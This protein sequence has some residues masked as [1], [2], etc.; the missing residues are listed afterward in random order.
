ME[1]IKIRSV[2]LLMMGVTLT[3][4]AQKSSNTFSGLAEE[5]THA[6][7]RVTHSVSGTVSDENGEPIIGA[8]IHARKSGEVCVT[9]ANGKFS[10]RVSDSDVLS[11]SYVGFQTKEVV[12]KDQKEVKVVL[13]EDAAL[14]DEFVVIGYGEVKKKDLT[15]SVANVEGDVISRMQSTSLGQSLQGLMAGVDVTRS[16]STPNANASIKVR[17]IT[18]I[19][20]SSPLIVV[21]GV[22]VLS[23]EDVDGDM[24]E[25]VTVLKDAASASIYGSRAAAGVIL[26][27]TK[28]AQ[29]GQL[30]ISYNGT[31]GITKRTSMPGSVTTKRY[32]EM[33]NE[34][35]WNDGGNQEGQE[36]PIY[37]KEY[38]DNYM[39]N[40]AKDPDQYPLTDWR[41]LMLKKTATRQKHR[42]SMTYGNDVIKT[43][44]MVSYEKANALYK[45]YDYERF[46]GRVNSDIKFNKYISASLDLN[47]IRE[48]EDA[49][50]VNPLY[51]ALVNGPTVAALW[52]DGRIGEAHNGSNT[53]ARLEYGGTDSYWLNRFY[54]KLSI[55]LT[56]FR[57]FSITGV[58]NPSIST[59]S[60][61]TFI[62]Q[63]PY[64]SAEDPLQLMG[65]IDGHMTSS[66]TE[67]RNEQKSLTKQLLLNYQTQFQGKHNLALMAGYEDYYYK[68]ENLSVSGDRF[69]LS[70]FPY[71]DRAP[72]DYLSSS[73]NATENAYQSYFGRVTYDYKNRYLLQGNIRCDGSSR[74]HKDHRWGTFPSVSAGWV[75]T[76]EP[77][78]KKMGLNKLDFLKL[79]A[80]YGTLGNER[81]GN[82]PYQSIMNLHTVIM[83]QN[84]DIVTAT[85]AAQEVYNIRDISWETTTSWNIGVDMT[86]LDGRLY[87][88]GDVYRKNTKDMLLSLEIPSF[89]G[90]SR[91]SQN[92]GDMHT[93]GWEIQATWRDKI[94]DVR[95][96]VGFHISD[97]RSIMGNLSGLVMDSDKIICEGSEYNEWYGYVSDGLFQSDEDIKNSA[98][99]FENVRP[100]D[101]KYKDISGPEGVPDGKISA[102]YDRVTLG[103]SLPRF[104]Y[105]GNIGLDWKGIDFSLS[106]QGVGKQKCRM[107][108]KMV[109][110]TTA[111][112]T[113]PELIEGK[114]W[115]EYNTAEE[116]LN[117]R[118]PRLSQVGFKSNNYV[119]SDFWL[120]NGAYFRCKN[121]TLGYSLP[122]KL[123]SKVALKNLRIYASVT[124]PFVFSHFPKGWDPEQAESTYIARTWNFGAIV[125][126]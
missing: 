121:I 45:H 15:G 106:F 57:G 6:A 70:E 76:E 110:Q 88:T 73:G 9:D 13:K 124:D 17:G 102:E 109:Y 61:K 97:Y 59:P 2:L 14:L 105:G 53:Y 39:E 77:F 116:N 34:V 65:Y 27:T 52:S 11:F 51:A 20:D 21:D 83:H 111:W 104:N 12:L 80:S 54:G 10:I 24:V 8:S 95:Y 89:M 38:I 92:A 49:P 43:N 108:D 64:Y 31:L 126:F 81:I 122:K 18:T 117:A 44:A 33:M 3:T 113:F 120:F 125:S 115:S 62:K 7:V 71:M 42:L 86:L 28:R 87:L 75:L 72:L 69:E 23:L 119:M 98:L 99:L 107:T 35:A 94:G 93:N 85:S 22:P 1:G 96:S 56:P 74:F 58:F 16:S 40:H 79:R 50:N 46:N 55:I 100:G 5:K 66:L 25:N 19:G 114:Y 112:F 32:L 68:A 90:Y 123:V 36:Y 101:I 67:K 47:V 60:R 30:N 48:E 103:G 29:K 37:S 63:I 41:E 91:P 82:Y 4:Y 118:F 84:N 26:I 78:F